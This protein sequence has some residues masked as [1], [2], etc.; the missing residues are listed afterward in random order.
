MLLSFWSL[1]ELSSALELLERIIK[2][3]HFLSNDEPYQYII[4]P[5]NYRKY[6][7]DFL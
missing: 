1:T 4:I 2:N 6:K 7:V 5:V 3:F